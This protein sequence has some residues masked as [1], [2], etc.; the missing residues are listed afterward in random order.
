MELKTNET[1]CG[2]AIPPPSPCSGFFAAFYG[3]KKADTTPEKINALRE[4]FIREPMMVTVYTD[5]EELT[6]LEYYIEHIIICPN[7]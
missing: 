7:K 5:E 3:C 6:A 1:L 4:V 2:P